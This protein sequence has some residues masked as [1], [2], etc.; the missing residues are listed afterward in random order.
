[1]VSVLLISTVFISC[2][3]SKPKVDKLALMAK[4][5]AVFAQLPSTMPGSENDTPDRIALGKNYILMFVYQKK[6]INRAILVT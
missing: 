3:E 2:G 6:T 4:A 1:M 5:N